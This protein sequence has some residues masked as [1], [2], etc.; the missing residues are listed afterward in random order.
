MS[1]YNVKSSNA[2]IRKEIQNSLTIHRLFTKEQK[3][4]HKSNR[5]EESYSIFINIYSTRTKWDEN[6]AIAWIDNKSHTIW[7]VKLDNKL[8]QNVQDNIRR[9]KPV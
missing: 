3:E 6:L 5:G 2:Q 9:Q 8:P 1:T 7:S 4:C